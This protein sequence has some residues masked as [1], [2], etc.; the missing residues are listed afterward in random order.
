MKTCLGSIVLLIC[1]AV[2]AA[3]PATTLKVWPGK[4]PGDEKLT[5][6]PEA[7]LTKPAD[8]LVGGARII[9]LGNVSVPTLAVFRPAKDKDTGAAV[10]ICPGGGHHIL[11]YD[12]EGTEVA[13]WLNTLGVTGIVL[14]YRVPGRDKEKRWLA[15]VQDAQRGMSLV[16]SRASELGIDAKRIGILGFS[17][18]GEVAALTAVF[19]E[20]QY[21]AVDDVDQVSLRPDFAVLVYPAYLVD[22]ADKTKLRG[23][24]HVTKSTPPMFLAHAFDD[25]V[26]PESSLLLCLALKRAGVA[27]ELH[28][29]DRGGHGYGLR[30]TDMLVTTWPKRCEEWLK[31]NKLLKR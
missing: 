19:T 23:D 16:R 5:L 17:A 6:P 26:T 7:D 31:T 9:K 24:M 8:N 30:P 10:A 14:K 4:P 1:H 13:E 27:S 28:L 2:A 21:S 18:G 25:G 12:L 11:A 22:P 29:Y 3:E 15:A 20:R